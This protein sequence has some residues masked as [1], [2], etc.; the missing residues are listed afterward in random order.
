MPGPGISFEEAVAF[1]KRPAKG[2]GAVARDGGA[3]RRLGK[4]NAHQ[5]PVELLVLQPGLPPRPVSTSVIV[6]VVS[7]WVRR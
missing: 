5:V 1:R 2:V 7:C 4:T 3:P 6:P